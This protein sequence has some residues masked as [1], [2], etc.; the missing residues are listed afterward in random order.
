MG[1]LLMRHLRSPIGVF[2]LIVLA[3]IG[4]APGAALAGLCCTPSARSAGSTCPH[5]SDATATPDDASAEPPQACPMHQ[6]GGAVDNSAPPDCCLRMCGCT[7][8]PNHIALTSPGVLTPAAAGGPPAVCTAFA[9]AITPI[10]PQITRPP[11]FPPP[12]AYGS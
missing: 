5:H 2:A 7:E 8:V 4:G 6:A 9:F 10:R 11:L 1:R 12:R 3:C